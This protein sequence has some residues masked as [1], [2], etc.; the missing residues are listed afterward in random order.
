MSVQQLRPPVLAGQVAAARDTIT[1]AA[2]A[3]LGALPAGEVGP[4][5]AEIAILESQVAALKLALLAEA[6]RRRLAEET[7]ATDTSAWAAALTGTTAAVMAGGLFLARRLEETYH[8]T[9]AAFARGRLS[10]AQVRV[11]VKAAEAMPAAATDT[12]REQAEA[13][14]VELACGGM[15]PQRLRRK[16]RR[17]L[18]RLS[19]E[20]ADEHEADSLEKEEKRA[21]NETW[22]SLHDNGDGTF[23]GRFVIPELH[24]HLLRNHLERLTSPR[25]RGRNKAGQPVLDDTMD[26]ENLSWTEHLGVGFCELLEHLPTTGH[27]P[28]GATLMITLDYQHLLDGLAS[29]RLDT[30]VTISAGQ[31]RRLSCNAGIIP[32][33]LDGRSRPLDVGRMK[34]LHTDAMRHALS[35]QHDTCAAEGCQRPFAWSEIHHPHAWSEGGVTS[36]HNAIPLC[37]WHH[38][39]IHDQHYTHTYLPTREVR[40]RR[41]RPTPNWHEHQPTGATPTRQ[42]T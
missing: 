25:R 14:L 24:G 8:H 22:L 3:P 20:L 28:A 10:V 11:I 40:F 27:G 9:R 31:A 39:R 17:M 29:A 18:E 2:A 33:V 42:R 5:L 26:T 21:A 35:L 6:D 12:Q 4:V 19:T 16:A 34:R 23:S 36:I 30:G 13:D 7:A 1:A 38:Q 37:G 15:D 32:A 41:R